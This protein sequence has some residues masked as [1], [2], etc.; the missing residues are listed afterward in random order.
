MDQIT[1]GTAVTCGYCGK[2]TIVSFV[3]DRQGTEAYDLAC[4]HR[5]AVCPTCG[6]LVRDSS[7][8]IYEVQPACRDCNPEMFQEDEEE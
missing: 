1:T 3:T 8:S 7:D 5:N 6:T 4:L 2:K